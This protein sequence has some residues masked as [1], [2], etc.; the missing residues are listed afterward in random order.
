LPER[1]L[2]IFSQPLSLAYTHAFRKAVSGT[3][4]IPPNLG[5]GEA[6]IHL[7]E[8]VRGAAFGRRF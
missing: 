4:S 7:F 8:D 3:V 6:D 5:A 2:G 1:R